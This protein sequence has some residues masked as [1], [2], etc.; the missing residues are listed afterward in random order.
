ML[1][2]SKAA[3]FRGRAI[4]AAALFV[5]AAMLLPSR[6]LPARS[7]LQASPVALQASQD[8]KY[9]SALAFSRIQ[10]LDRANGWGLSNQGVLRTADGG[11]TWNVILSVDAGPTMSR[12]LP[13]VNAAFVDRARAW[14]CRVAIEQ[15]GPV[16]VSRTTDGGV[17]WATMAV[18]RSPKALY[19]DGSLQGCGLAILNDRT[20][21][22][23]LVPEHGMGSEPGEL[24]RTSDGGSSWQFVSAAYTGSGSLPH[25]GQIEFRDAKTGWLLGSVDTTTPSIFSVTEDGGVTWCRDDLPLPKGLSVAKR[26]IQ[27]LPDLPM[28][29]DE[30]QLEVQDLPQFFA[31]DR[32]QGVLPSRFMTGPYESAKYFI[33][34]YR[35]FDGGRTWQPGEP[36]GPVVFPISASDFANIEKGWVWSVSQPAIPGKLYSTADGGKTWAVVAGNLP[37]LMAER[38]IQQLDFVDGEYGWALTAPHLVA[39]QPVQT[40][41]LFGTVDGGKTWNRIGAV[42]TGR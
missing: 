40:T 12:E 16:E 25:G 21:W 6:A 7:N 9:G 34:I 13:P 3:L 37:Q 36:I 15:S 38:E 32:R 11:K 31:A 29:P 8:A 41:E 19:P 39:G 27:G 28:P 24:Y 5:F 4:F 33:V 2:H 1:T 18:P 30:V 17:H 23:M 35:T 26:E 10:M 20:A 22:L 42:Y 14:V